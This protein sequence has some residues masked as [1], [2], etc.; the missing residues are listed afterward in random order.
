MICTIRGI[1]GFEL[2]LG[3]SLIE[4]IRQQ[5]QARHF[6][7]WRAHVLGF[8]VLP[9]C[10]DGLLDQLIASLSQALNGPF[11]RPAPVF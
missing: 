9:D 2:E 5:L 7:L 11:H 10:I 4:R 8:V 3:D 6:C 1:V